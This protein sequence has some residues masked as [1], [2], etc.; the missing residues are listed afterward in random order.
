MSKKPRN[1]GFMASAARYTSIAMTLPSAVVGGYFLGYGLD[2]WLHTTY[3]KIVF[4]LLGI[5]AGFYELIRF[6]MRDMNDNRK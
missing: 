2:L 4:L 5:V 1:D 3:L 6:L